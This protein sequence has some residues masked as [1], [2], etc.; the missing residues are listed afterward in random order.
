M[1]GGAAGVAAHVRA[2]AFSLPRQPGVRALGPRGG[3]DPA[4]T[5]LTACGLP[6]TCPGLPLLSTNPAQWAV[7]EGLHADGSWESLQRC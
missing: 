1:G 7:E 6:P 4:A 5:Q 2:A 3:F